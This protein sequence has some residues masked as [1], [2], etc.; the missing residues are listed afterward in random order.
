MSNFT[1][2]WPGPSAGPY[3]FTQPLPLV[4]RAF[5]VNYLAGGAVESIC[6]SCRVLRVSSI[7]VEGWEMPLI[8]HAWTHEDSRARA[9]RMK[10]AHPSTPADLESRSLFEE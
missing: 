8:E 1:D 9:P 7:H 6:R 4:S 2:Q 3:D 5:V 10:K